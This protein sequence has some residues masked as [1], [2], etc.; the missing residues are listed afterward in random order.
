MNIHNITEPVDNEDGSIIVITLI[1]LMLVTAMG[2]SATTTST[3]EVQ[4]AGNDRTYKENFYLADS[5]V[6]ENAQRIENG[7]DELKDPITGGGPAWFIDSSA[8]NDLDLDGVIDG[9]EMVN[10]RNWEDMNADDPNPGDLA[11]TAPW[12]TATTDS[13]T[14]FFTVFKGITTG[15]SLDI[16]RSRLYSYQI[17]SRTSRNN[18]LI[19]LEG[20]FRR[21]F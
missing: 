13:N 11:T 6:Y 14:L 10:I 4:I 5:A 7:G 17:N 18:G 21:A 19:F 20:G 9:A 3:I 2:L 8:L 15:S 1:M 12:S 16:S